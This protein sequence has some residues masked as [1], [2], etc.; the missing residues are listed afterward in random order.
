M[1]PLALSLWAQMPIMAKVWGAQRP[2]FVLIC[3]YLIGMISFQSR[4]PVRVYFTDE[5]RQ[6]DA[7]WLVGGW[8]SGYLPFITRPCALNPLVHV[9]LAEA[10]GKEACSELWFETLTF[11]AEIFWSGLL[12]FWHHE[13][14]LHQRLFLG[15]CVDLASLVT[16]ICI[17]S[18]FLNIDV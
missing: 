11:G 18:W 16:E 9:V 17:Q 15:Q 12:L 1:L 7:H 2:E 14:V 8:Y 6:G 5:K 4:F 10:C 3:L 13:G